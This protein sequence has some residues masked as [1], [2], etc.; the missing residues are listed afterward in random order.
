MATKNK[1]LSFFDLYNRFIS[2]SKKGKRLQPNGKRISEG[3]IKN[4]EYTSKILQGFCAKKGFELRI[5]SY[6][7]L[8]S[9]E[10]EREKNYWK[11]FYKHFTDYLYNTCG[12]F[13]NYAG[14]IIKNIKAFF[15]YLNKELALAVGEF[16]K[17]FYVRKEE[18]SI[19]T[20]MPEELNYLIFDKEFEQSLSMRMK[21]VKDVFVF[22]CTVALRVSDLIALK[23]SS[24]R[25]IN[26]QYY[27]AVRSQKTNTD[28]LVKLPGYA[29]A[30]INK[31]KTKKGALL[32]RFNKSNLNEYIKQ[33][34][35]LAGFKNE[36][37]LHR[38][39]RGKAIELKKEI[40]A[41]RFCDVASTHIMR[42][43]AITTMLCLGM[44]EQLV[45]KISGHS[46]NTKEF[47]RYVLWAQAYMD[48]ETE[49][50]F[51]KLESKELKLKIA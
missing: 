18:I 21:E 29:I 7:F 13:D 26:N 37:L 16:H 17:Q 40:Q 1:E 19:F 38:T 46:A 23:K 27:L 51:D 3:T 48:Q 14:L 43:T 6:R 45:R 2:D 32:P 49:K 25:I 35:E 8:S 24:L 36:V 9:R 42:R 44:P 10:A 41:Y 12:Y 4:Y 50:V 11:K 20:L 22:G 47:Y 5:K 34:L 28:T 30:I 31:Y 39:R 15:N 33:L